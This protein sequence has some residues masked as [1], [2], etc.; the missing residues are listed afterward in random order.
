MYVDHLGL[1]DN[2]CKGKRRFV[3]QKN[4]RSVFTGYFEIQSHR[5]NNFYSGDANCT[6]VTT[7]HAPSSSLQC[8]VICAAQPAESCVAFYYNQIVGSCHYIMYFD[9]TLNIEVELEWTKYIRVP[10]I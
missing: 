9:V 7:A 4:T 3:C 2:P 6:F 1:D 5:Q 8:G 10:Q